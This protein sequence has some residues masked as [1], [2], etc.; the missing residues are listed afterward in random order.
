MLFTSVISTLATTL[1]VMAPVV[2]AAPGVDTSAPELDTRAPELDTRAAD[3]EITWR[4]VKGCSDN[5]GPRRTLTRDK[6]VPLSDTTK[7]VRVHNHKTG[8]KSKRNPPP[9]SLK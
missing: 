6:C 3:F 2:T 8:L 5:G 4:S 9:P 1:A 7:A